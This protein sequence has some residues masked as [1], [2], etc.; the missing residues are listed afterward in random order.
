MNT[1]AIIKFEEDL[2]SM[3]KKLVSAKKDCFLADD[4]I[5][6][7]QTQEDEYRFVDAPGSK[8]TDIQKLVKKLDITN[9]FILIRTANQNIKN[10]VEDVAKY[11]APGDQTVFD[12]EIVP[13]TYNKKV[14]KYT[15]TACKKMWNH[16]YIGTDS[17]VNPCCLADHRFPIGNLTNSSVHDIITSD[18]ANQIRANM[19]QGFRVRACAHCYDREDQNLKSGRGSFDPT[20]DEKIQITNL[21]IR[22][23]NVCNFKCRS[24]SEYFSSAIQKET[25]ELYGKD[26]VLGAE[27]NSLIAKT[28]NDKLNDFKKIQPYL[29][30]HIKSIYFA[31]GEPLIMH[32]HYEILSHLLKHKLTSVDLSYN[33]NLS[34]LQYKN[35]SVLDIWKN[36]DNVSVGASIDASG[37]VAEYL[38]HGTIWSEILENLDSIKT[39]TPHVNLIIESTVGFLNVENL[40]KLQKQWIDSEYFTIDQLNVRICNGD[41]L[42]PAVPPEKYKII[43]N[44]KITNHVKYLGK[45]TLA[46][47]WKDVLKYMMNNDY[48]DNLNHFSQR[49]QTLDNHRSESFAD[50]FPEF[51]DL[52]H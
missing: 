41:L 9:C 8:I 5:V 35:L 1:L 24:C 48:S 44:K 2:R 46:Q 33:T 25:V 29:N 21:D 4:R 14:K 12:Y 22:L 11:Y 7:E 27:E 17:N 18:N 37:K 28:K 30:D 26:A 3:H 42:N 19:K 13:G 36:F 45:C 40:I 10:E 16:L 15:N 31:G 43:L 39:Q 51:A 32:E 34:K 47:Q 38:R 50:T 52:L 49:M 23:S 6:I 20:D